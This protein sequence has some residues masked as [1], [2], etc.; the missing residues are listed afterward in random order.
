M[1]QREVNSEKTRLWVV[2]EVYYPEETST[3]YYLTAIAEGLADKFDVKVICGQP[4]YSRR[5]VRAPKHENHNR[6][7]IFRAAGARLDKNVV[8]YR[9]INMLTLG[10]SVL[11]HGVRRF[12]RGDRVLVV[13]TPPSMPFIVAIASLLRGASYVLL[14]H[15]SYP[16]VLVAVKKMRTDSTT[17]RTIDFLNRWLFKHARKIIVVGRDMAELVTKKAAGL[18][19]RVVTIPNWAEIDH[20]APRPRTES[21]LIKEQGIGDKL[22]I[23]HAG[24]IGHPTDVKSIIECF[25]LLNGDNR[26]QFVFIGSGVK[27]KMLEEFAARAS[28]DGLILLESRPRS[29]QIEFLNACDVGLSSLGDGML[30]AAVPSK[31]YNLMAAG[32]PLLAITHPASELARMIDE[33]EIGWHLG[34][35]DPEALKGALE[36]VYKQRASLREIGTRARLAAEGKYSPKTAIDHYAMELQ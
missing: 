31:A 34:P 20:V 9:L 25:K 13:T 35:D 27:K 36:G 11:L 33:E 17:V 2:S 28:F 23:L 18:D 32:K 29:E 7:E 21:S 24:N 16:E 6:T 15:D 8:I 14:I 3:G 19:V 30:G 1:P 12:R 26:F 5:G 22:V 4:N 10:L